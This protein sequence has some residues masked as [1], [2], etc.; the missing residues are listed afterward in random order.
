MPKLLRRG[1]QRSLLTIAV[2]GL[3][4]AG[5]SAEMP[6][7]TYEIEFGGEYAIVDVGSFTDCS[8]LFG[9][10]LCLTVD[11]VPNGRGRY[12]GAAQIEVSGA[13]SGFL[14]GP[15]TAKLGKGGRRLG[16]CFETQGTIQ[17]A[18]T[19]IW[20]CLKG[21]IDRE[22]GEFVGRGRTRLKLTFLGQTV[23]DRVRA[24]FETNFERRDWT[25]SLF[26]FPLD[27]KRIAGTATA[28]VHGPVTPLGVAGDG[29]DYLFDVRGKY[30]SRRDRADLSLKALDDLSSGAKL[31]IGNL[32]VSGS[33]V[34]D[35]AIRY[36][37]QGVSGRSELEP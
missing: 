9:V 36:S 1:L 14:M 37:V 7:A 2:A 28:S 16:V 19:E 10:T 12:A 13:L 5:A 8:S 23:K 25:L 20:G 27:G 30:S 21:G 29:N 26:L 22:T 31:K 3:A 18:P 4:S 11:M 34:L 17:T 32:V 35:G 15:A 24:Q 33:D 6:D